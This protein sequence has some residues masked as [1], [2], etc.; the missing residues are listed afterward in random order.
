MKVRSAHSGFTMRVWEAARR[1]EVARHRS[2]D[3]VIAKR[4]RELEDL[5]EAARASNEAKWWKDGVLAAAARGRAAGKEVVKVFRHQRQRDKAPTIREL[6]KKLRAHG[7]RLAG[8]GRELKKLRVELELRAKVA[9]LRARSQ[10]T[11]AP[12]WAIRALG[13]REALK[14]MYGCKSSH[15]KTKPKGHKPYARREIVAPPGPA[16]GFGKEK[17]L[18]DIRARIR[19]ERWAE[20]RARHSGHEPIATG[21][22]LARIA[23]E[24]LLSKRHQR[25][26]LVPRRKGSKPYARREVGPTGAAVWHLRPVTPRSPPMIIFWQGPGSRLRIGWNKPGN[27]LVT[28]DYHGAD[29]SYR[30]LAEADAAVRRLLTQ[31]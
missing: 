7:R 1:L 31:S 21:H 6:G 3:S 5:L 29:G 23:Y 27:T 2:A 26:D 20:L 18:A 16:S 10:G 30:T 17:T 12:E 15:D 4:K 24:G 25:R 9:I 13:Q 11:P 19:W 28:V 8:T 14:I 22:Q